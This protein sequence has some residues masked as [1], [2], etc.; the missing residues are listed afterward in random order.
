MAQQALT[1]DR[2]KRDDNQPKILVV[3]DRAENHRVFHTLL[4]G[5]DAE[6]IHAYNGQ[7]AVSLSLRM[8]F[9]V[10]LMDI[11]MPVMDGFETAELI[12][13]NHETR[14][15]PIIFVTA[16]EKNEEFEQLSYKTGAVDFITKPI[17]ASVLTGKVQ[18]FLDLAEQR[19]LVHQQLN[20]L[21][22]LENRNNLLLRSIGEGILGLDP[23]GAVTFSNP[24]AQASLNMTEAQLEQASFNDI[25][26]H[27]DAEQPEV[28]WEELPARRA[29]MAGETYHEAI[30][31]FWNG[32]KN[33]FPVEYMATPMTDDGKL[34]GIVIAFQDITERRRTEEQLARLAQYDALTG[35]INRNAFNNNLKKALSRAARHNQSLAILF[36][37]LDQFKSVNDSHGHEVGDSLLQEA[38]FRLSACIRKGDV[39]GRLGGDEFIILLESTKTNR[40]AATVSQNIINALHKPFQ[41]KGHEVFVGA[42]IGISIYPDSAMTARELLR[43]ADIAMYRAKEE[44]RNG[45]RY[46]TNQMQANVQEAMQLEMSLRHAYSTQKFDIHFQPKYQLADNRLVGAEVLI[47]WQEE[48]GT[49]IPP[50]VFIPKAEE[51]GL[52]NGIGNWVFR[53]SCQ[54]IK[55]WQEEGLVDSDCIFAI[56]ISMRQL[57]SNN[58]ISDITDI[59]TDTGINPSCLELEVTES[60]MMHDPDLTISVLNELHDLDIRI[61]IDDFG[62]GYS[63]LSHLRNLPIDALKIDKSFVFSMDDNAQ[64]EAII[65][66][67]IHLG[68]S[69]DMEV[70]AEG[71][72]TEQHRNFLHSSGCDLAQGYYFNRPM[73]RSDFKQYL[74]SLN[75]GSKSAGA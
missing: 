46:F 25:I 28:S 10:I 49:W 40:D 75:G 18:V 33:L 22:R 20:D 32:N 39:L 63:S 34:V 37:D 16:A 47:R 8:P 11:M 31:V 35:L 68:H 67:I 9:A 13:L 3:D 41:I 5:L 2:N 6:I 48:D 72:E 4:E 56:N 59:L 45:Y 62:T 58:L 14:L 66:T 55:T 60:T 30:G 65:N 43:C 53:E 57:V 70:V 42:S 1:I 64:N 27:G 26:Y 69:L 21:K 12:R 36:I 17:K 54:T 29:C 23:S 52:I 74:N 19:N 61:A 7:D 73:N 71:V 15:T 51:I 50:D 38:A 24:A 44:G